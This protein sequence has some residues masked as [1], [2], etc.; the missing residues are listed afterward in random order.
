MQRRS[1]LVKVVT[2]LAALGVV[3]YLFALTLRDVASE[4][5]TVRPDRLQGWRVETGQPVGP[6]GPLLALR[7]PAPMG[8]FDQ[9]FQRTMESFTSPVAPGIALVLRGELEAATADAISGADL[10]EI[11]RT[12]GL[13]AAPLEP[14]CMAVHRTT[15]GREQRL[16]FVLFDMPQFDRFRGALAELIDERGGDRS[17][18][19]PDALSPALLVASSERATLRQLPSRSQLEEDCEAPVMVLGGGGSSER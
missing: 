1:A 2:S 15:G 12:V 5:Y 4:P 19:D 17:R 16:F 10:L 9:V 13:A 11:A 8:L 7:P 3:G 14:R 6:E 18:F